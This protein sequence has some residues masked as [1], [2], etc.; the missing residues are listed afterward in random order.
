[1]ASSSDL[2]SELQ[3]LLRREAILYSTPSAPI[4]HRTGEV[5]AWAF[6]SWGISLSENG[7]RL[8]AREILRALQ[9]FGSTQLASYGY[10]GL[11]LLS[12]CVLEGGGRYSGLSIREKRKAYLTNR[13]VDGV[14]DRSRPVVIID[15]SLSSGTSLHK[16]ITALEDEGLEVEGTIAL[17]HFPYRGAKE[18]ANA[19][20]Y[21]TVTLFDI[22]SDL[23][24]AAADPQYRGSERERGEPSSGQ[25]TDGLAPAELARRAAEFFLRTRKVPAP[26][27]R[28]DQSY[29]ARGGTFVSFR[30]RADDH[31]VARDGFWHFD[32]ANAD[33]ACDV[34][35]ATIDTLSR[36]GSEQT[37][38]S[39][40]DLKVAV[41]FFGPLEEIRPAQLDFGRY[42]I[43]VRSKVWP[44]KLG[45][46]LPNTQVFIS[47][48]EQYRHARK[49]NARVADT[50]PHELYR[51][52]VAKF[53]EAG[54]T[55]PPYGSEEDAATSWWR[56]ETI[57]RRLTGRA[58]DAIAALGPG[59][60]AGLP[61]GGT[62]VP[63][64]VEG[65]AVTLYR[66]GLAGYGLA[67]ETDLDRAVVAAAEAA[68]RDRRY[69]A[70]RSGGVEEMAVVVS[71]LHHGEAIEDAGRLVIERKIRR[72]LDAVTLLQGGERCTL[73]PSALVYNDWS[74]KQFLDVLESLAGHNHAMRSW[75]THQ[76]AAWVS[77]RGRVLPLRFGFPAREPRRYDVD[78]CAASVDLLAGYIARAID[79]SGVP[80]Y[81]LAPGDGGYTRTGTAGRVLHGLYALRIA[82][83][84][85]GRRDWMDAATR[86]VSRCLQHVRNGMIDLPDHAG[87]ALAD[88]VLLAA[89]AVCGL[90]R[91]PSCREVAGR[92]R[93]LVHDS[94]WIGSGAKRLDN[95]QDQE[96]L[97]G[98]AVWALATDCRVT[99]TR[100]PAALTAARH[101]Y[102]NR[103]REYPTW[104]CSWL[105]QGWSAVH[106]LTGDGED[107]A[108]AFAA[109]DWVAERQLEKNGAFLEDLSPDEPSFNAGF[110]AEG[111]AGAWRTA[112]RRNEAERVTRY[113]QCWRRA[114]EFLTTLTLEDTDVF[115]FRL[116]ENAVGGVR[117]TVS[118][119]G[120]RTDQVSH[121][122]HALVEGRQ[123]LLVAQEHR[124]VRRASG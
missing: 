67:H 20:G 95:P 61:L 118:R 41:T 16:A 65:V 54:A 59:R 85:R 79:A 87:G 121:G 62:P 7:L 14:I 113:E 81:H 21:R 53:A 80:A 103:F 78:R 82:G 91:T 29:D 50:E 98:A 89:A 48:I 112:I 83:E 3:D 97:P 115:P 108:L 105:A 46:A 51:H 75:R 72:G 10:T 44:N 17:V 58:R 40:P 36:S 34:V 22:W 119:A 27:A 19:A 73:L 12:A 11:P 104:G 37:L 96:Y 116:P 39:L 60:K 101:F 63:V 71:V 1:M 123:N 25:M 94:G 93:G 42:G 122:L 99:D 69:A 28:L 57:G 49:T 13:R 43:V 86:G 109:A 45:G 6:Y 70:T 100:L 68:W 64:P 76:V 31:R 18:W 117:C 106:D 23:G 26:P 47:E 8:A 52:T 110:M 30:R 111:V 24:M 56:D 90:G 35:L 2:R 38:A 15:D 5:S 66:N 74:R 102:G 9:S 55:W 124:P 84:A 92:V 4:T 33:A 120:I 32:A 114:A 88:A 77:D 107:A